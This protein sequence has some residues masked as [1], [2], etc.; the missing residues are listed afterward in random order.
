[1]RIPILAATSTAC[2]LMSP[3][4]GETVLRETSVTATEPEAS[5][6]ASDPQ[7]T[8][9]STVTAEGLDLLGGPG[10]T[11]ILRP[12]NLL[13]SVN[14][15]SADP[16]GLSPSRSINI[17]GKGDFH[18][19][20]NI[21]GLP[22]AGIVGGADLFDL[23]NVA[24]LDAYR[25]GVL[26]TQAFG[27]SNA[28]GA[29]DEQLRTP[30]E[31][32]GLFG[33]VAAGS[34]GFR[35]AFARADSGDIGSLGT[36]LFVSG[37]LAGTDKWKGKGDE[38]RQNVMLG[39]RQSFGSRAVLDLDVVYSRFK[40]HSYRSLN[41]AQASDLSTYYKYDYNANLSGDGAADINYY[42]FNRVD[43]RNWAALAQLDVMLTD[44][45]HL[46][47]KPYYWYD[48]G[49]Q[50]S[51]SGARNVQIW[52]Q[53]ND[54]YGAVLEYSGRFAN[55]LTLTVGDWAQSMKPPPPPTNQVRYTVTAGGALA[56]ANWATLARIDR[57]KVNS[58]Y[59]QLTLEAGRTL[60][61]AGVRYMSLGAP[62]MNY[63][64]TTGLPNVS[65]DDV[66][67]YNPLLDANATVAGRHYNQLLP[68]LG[69]SREINARLGVS[70]SYGRKFGRP[71]WGP[72][73][74]NYLGNE[75]AFLARGI[76]L[77]M[78]VDH[79]RA[80]ISD[81]IDLSARYSAGGLK[82]VPTVFVARNRNRQV[83]IV[84]PALG[85]TLSYYTG[86][87]KTTA[88]GVE[89]EASYEFAPDWLLFGS[90]TVA[91]E[92]YDQDTPVLTGGATLATEGK[93]I[94]NTPRTM[95]KGGFTYR[96]RGLTLS[97]IIRFV[98]A[99]YGDAIEVQKV[100]AYTAVDAN[101]SYQ[102]GKL[103]RFDLAAMNLLDRH[104]IAQISQNDFNLNG[105]SSY[106]ASPPR[107]VALT[108][109]ATF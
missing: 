82:L 96:H 74:S 59:A 93:Q 3:A 47:F 60:V 9:K 97:P 26:A 19:T 18:V 63:Y 32:W 95:L 75:A 64:R 104:Y 23:E 66:W 80:E 107:A 17:R 45:Q 46:R 24:Q 35:R 10:G 78:L 28:T 13:P 108:V 27:I 87:A 89:L 100:P 41:W 30:A 12:L 49:V 84:D 79:V 67:A 37:S 94:A 85:G 105:A 88:R 16:Y 6:M 34:F 48:D 103:L 55:G 38:T 21:N 70:I 92:T 51:A 83:Q 8:P 53:Q 68:N 43:Y 56:F 4:F 77:Q 7:P 44:G 2:L 57:F 98:G 86:T 90:A 52:F 50:Y 106:Q 5:V 20:R 54:N 22:L 109:S 73:A 91:S 14:Y 29:V 15:E 33:K 1:M 40:G 58:P 71:D 99:R 39:L 31:H 102:P 101:V 72:Q 65:Y 36:R 61:S 42:D 25:G 76:T 81:Q 11:S 62:Q 69:V